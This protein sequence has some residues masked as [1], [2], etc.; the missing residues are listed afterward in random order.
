MN[1]PTSEAVSSS[2][3][4]NV[5]STRS[6]AALFTSFRRAGLV[7]AV[8]SLPLISACGSDS[9]TDAD[10]PKSIAIAL[11][12]TSATIAQAG[13]VEF[14]A[15]VSRLGGF[16]GVVD[17]TV[18]DV[19]DGITGAVSN[20]HTANDITTATITLSA[21]AT[22]TTGVHSVTVRGSSYG[23]TAATGFSLTVTPAP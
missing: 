17:V 23:V 19:T 20:L 3:R 5:R 6:L 10:G 15:S 21:S 7:L 13:T 14:T 18:E 22:A 12:T 9:P 11:S 2:R 16:V 1:P 8:S 4:S